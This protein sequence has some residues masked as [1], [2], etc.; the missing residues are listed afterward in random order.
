MIRGRYA[1]ESLSRV[2]PDCHQHL[3]LHNTLVEVELGQSYCCLALRS[4]PLDH[5]SPKD[6]MILPMV[7]PWVEKTH[8]RAGLRIKRADIFSLRERR[9]VVI[10]RPHFGD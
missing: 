9:P 8:Q 2:P 1:V 10:L 3:P 5:R 4:E 7:P 6:K